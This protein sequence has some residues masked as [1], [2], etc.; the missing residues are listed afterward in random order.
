[1]VGRLKRISFELLA[2]LRSA[3]GPVAA[4]AIRIGKL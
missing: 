2:S 4:G 1:M 3:Q